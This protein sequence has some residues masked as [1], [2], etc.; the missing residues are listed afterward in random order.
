MGYMR[1]HTLAYGDQ[2]TLGWKS[3]FHGALKNR[4]C[5]RK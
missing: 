1:P 3:E 4:G 5:I 2:K